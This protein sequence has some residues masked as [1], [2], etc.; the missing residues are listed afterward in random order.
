MGTIELFNVP[1]DRY[2]K[3]MLRIMIVLLLIGVLIIT[4]APYI[5]LAF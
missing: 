4:A 1:Y 5:R 3:F 2:L